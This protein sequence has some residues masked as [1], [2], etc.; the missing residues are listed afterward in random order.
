[1]NEDTHQIRALGVDGCAG[2]WIAVR[3]SADSEQLRASRHE[4]LSEFLT[5][6]PIPHVIAVYVPIGLLS[7]GARL[8]DERAR[9]ILGPRRSSVFPAP[10]RP[11]LGCKTHAEA[12]AVRRSIEGKGMSIQ[13]FGILAKVLEV[14]PVPGRA[15]SPATESLE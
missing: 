1:M 10:L 14:P 9:R 5:E 8:C 12:S 7:I 11:M 6:A 4:R 15:A 13:A 3:R 2:G